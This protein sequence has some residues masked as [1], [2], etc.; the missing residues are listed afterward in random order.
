MRRARFD[1]FH[2]QP[3]DFTASMLTIFTFAAC[4]VWPGSV[5]PTTPKRRSRFV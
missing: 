3:R 1:R 4:L 2:V 5:E